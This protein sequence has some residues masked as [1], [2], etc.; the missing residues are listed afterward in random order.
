MFA[1]ATLAHQISLLVPATSRYIALAIESDYSVFSGSFETRLPT[2]TVN[3][4]LQ[5]YWSLAD[6]HAKAKE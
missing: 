1:D 3:T 2:H 6:K 4:L 5:K